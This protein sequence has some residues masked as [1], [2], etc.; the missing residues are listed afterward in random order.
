[1]SSATPTQV[2]PDK[3]PVK[4]W[5]NGVFS[6]TL[7]DEHIAP[8]AF[9]I[10]SGRPGG[11]IRPPGAAPAPLQTGTFDGTQAAITEVYNR[12]LHR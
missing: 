2:N 6:A 11:L 1:M 5:N 7:R 9:D 10:V 4:E 8:R 12:I 3:L